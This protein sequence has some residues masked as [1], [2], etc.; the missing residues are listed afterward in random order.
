MQLATALELSSSAP[1]VGAP[2]GPG[3]VRKR[4]ARARVPAEF[5]VAGDPQ[6]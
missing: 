6:Q 2:V 1:C 3:V 4:S 5:I